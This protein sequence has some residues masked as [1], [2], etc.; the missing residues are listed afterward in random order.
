MK[1]SMAIILLQPKLD[2]DNQIEQLYKSEED[3]QFEL[4]HQYVWLS[5]FADGELSRLDCLSE[6]DQR[7]ILL[8]MW[9]EY[10]ESLLDS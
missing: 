6:D 3:K 10:L 4:I 2:L 5:S 7:S 9:I 8:D 1:V